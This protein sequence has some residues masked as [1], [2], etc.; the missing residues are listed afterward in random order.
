MDAVAFRI[1]KVLDVELEVDR[2]HYPVAEHLVDRTPRRFTYLTAWHL[3]ELRW[4]VGDPAGAVVGAGT[5]APLGG[6]DEAEDSCCELFEFNDGA[7][8]TCV[9][10]RLCGLATRLEDG[11]G[12]RPACAAVLGETAPV[13]A[14]GAGRSGVLAGCCTRVS[15]RCP[16]PTPGETVNKPANTRTANAAATTT[17]APMTPAPTTNALR[18]ASRLS[19]SRDARRSAFACRRPSAYPDKPCSVRDSAKGS[20]RARKSSSRRFT[21]LILAAPFV[22][23]QSIGEDS[24]LHPVHRS[25]RSFPLMRKTFPR[26]AARTWPDVAVLNR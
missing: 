5:G 6:V 17:A 9:P 21:V 8:G 2:A 26:S 3:L 24:G 4:H 23:D 14:L 18:I 7:A 1:G 10:A 12:E 20:V 13:V 19:L 22:V 11:R 16:P 15:V 25:T